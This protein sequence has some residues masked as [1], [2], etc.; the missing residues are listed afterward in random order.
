MIGV[1]THRQQP[2]LRY[3]M[4]L[5]VLH[6]FILPTVVS[7]LPLIDV[8]RYWVITSPP[9]GHKK[10]QKH[11]NTHTHTHTDV[12]C[13]SH[14]YSV[15]TRTHIH[16]GDTWNTHYLKSPPSEEAMAFSSPCFLLNFLLTQITTPAKGTPGFSVWR[17]KALHELMGGC[18][19][20]Y[21]KQTKSDE[22]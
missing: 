8:M 12:R 3:H 20:K 13:I 22:R 11:R 7:D 16:T 10:K 15:P 17:S 19:P 6:R 18:N 5:S 21:I 1:S 9:G 2:M 4:Q 14:R